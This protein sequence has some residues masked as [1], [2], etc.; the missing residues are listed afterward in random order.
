M[1]KVRNYH[2][3]GTPEKANALADDYR[4]L[5]REVDVPE[6]GHLVVFALPRPK[7]KKQ[8]EDRPVRDKE[9]RKNTY[10]ASK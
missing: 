6:P 9:S 5:G 10:R 1:A 8:E 2:Y 3:Y 7:V 4:F